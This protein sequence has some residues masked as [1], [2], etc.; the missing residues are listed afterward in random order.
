M[1][2]AKNRL[3]ESVFDDS[4]MQLDLDF[5]VWNIFREKERERERKRGLE[6]KITQANASV[7]SLEVLGTLIG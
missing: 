7:E 1:A 5:E 3:S 2:I 4:P 6:R